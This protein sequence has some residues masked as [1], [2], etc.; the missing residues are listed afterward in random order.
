MQGGATAIMDETGGGG[1]PSG[2]GSLERAARQ[3]LPDLAARAEAGSD[4]QRLSPET[5]A[6]FR[7]AGFFRLLQPAA[8]GGHEASPRILFRLQ[9]LLAEADMSASWVLANM[10]ILA[11][12]LALFDPR[13]QAD[14]WG[15]DP[16]AILASSNMP[17]GRAEP[18]AGGYRL[19][20]FWRFSSGVDHADWLILGG[21]CQAGGELEDGGLEPRAFLVPRDAVEIVRDWDVTGLRGTGSHALRIGEAFVPAHRTHRHADRFAGTSPGLTVNRSALYRLPLPQLQFRA[22]S[23]SSIGGLKGMLATFLAQNADRTSMMAQKIA[24]DPHVRSLCAETAA[25]ASE[26]LAAMEQS[27]AAMEEAVAAG[28]EPP[29]ED[30]RIYRLTAT[31][32]PE[33]CLALAAGLYRAAGAA[34]LYRGSPIGRMYQDLLAARQHAANQFELHGRALGAAL[35]GQSGEDVLL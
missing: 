27:F 21:L 11:F 10:G 1:M 25:T 32:V 22:V 33:R 23:T 2:L 16:G 35:F 18:V 28:G 13:A 12:H 15:A 5:V 3:M 31:M 8:L 14:V 34:A 30:R 26:M 24:E 19:S 17:G 7:Q 20:G 4:A 9:A 6:N 29:L